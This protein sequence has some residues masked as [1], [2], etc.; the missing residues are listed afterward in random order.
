MP[1][2]IVCLFAAKALFWIVE[3]ARRWLRPLLVGAAAFWLAVWPV[4]IL[5]RDFQDRND[6]QL[7]LLRT[8]FETTKPTDLVMDGWAGM[9]VFRPHAFHYFFLHA[10]TRAMLSPPRWD[11]YLDALESGTIRPKL[12]AMDKNLA[13]MGPRFVTF[14]QGTYVS[15]DGFFYFARQG[16]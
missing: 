5:R 9:G 10:E 16:S 2:P 8:V 6:R 1:L 14:V 12:I 15:R 11:A 3:R 4:R 7:A 13:A